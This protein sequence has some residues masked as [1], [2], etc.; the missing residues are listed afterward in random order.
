MKVSC[1]LDRCHTTLRARSGATRDR[2]RTIINPHHLVKQVCSADD[3]PD[4]A[5]SPARNLAD[6]QD[7]YEDIAQIV[8]CGW[9][10]NNDT[11]D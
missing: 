7:C 9:H 1:W 5:Q 2:R 6:Y 3:E 8:P 10:R 11:G 4:L